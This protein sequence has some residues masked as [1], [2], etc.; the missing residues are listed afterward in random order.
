[1]TTALFTHVACFGHEPPPGHPERPARLSAVLNSVRQLKAIEREASVA[2][3]ELLRHAHT[4][5]LIDSILGYW[6]EQASKAHYLRLDADT[7]MSAGSPEAALRAAGAVIAAIDGVM[8][9][10]F[11]NAF[12]AVRPP[13]HHAERN[14][15]MGFCLFNNIAVGAFHAR[16]AHGLKRIAV[17]DFDVHHG[18][19]TQGIFFGDP[20]SSTLRLTRC[21]SIQEQ[22]PQANGA[23]RTTC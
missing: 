3:T 6:N 19:G 11:Q 15:S 21:R 1:M 20:N 18:N 22:V 10:D 4:S 12:C 2:S 7:F 5:Q 13:G 8:D 9:G 23:W 16:Q 14:R 17:A